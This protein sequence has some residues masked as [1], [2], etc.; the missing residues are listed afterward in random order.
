MQLQC[1]APRTRLSLSLLT[2]ATTGQRVKLVL[3]IDHKLP[4]STTLYIFIVH[5]HVHVHCALQYTYNVQSTVYGWSV[6]FL[7]FRFVELILREGAH[8]DVKNKK[9]NSP[10]WL[11]ANGMYSTSCTVRVY[12]YNDIVH[13]C[14]HV[15]VFYQ[16]HLSLFVALSLSD[17]PSPP[18]SP[19]AGGHLDVVRLLVDH[20]SDLDSQDNRKV[21]CL[22]A[23]F[24]KVNT[25]TSSL[26]HHIVTTSSV[27]HT[28]CF[29]DTGT[30]QGGEVFGG[31]C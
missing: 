9:G 11:A 2:R 23:A 29:C 17:L 13:V 18:L 26:H 1:P 19:C 20:G 6:Q 3:M 15:H 10:L 22:M 25:M 8:V 7:H 16:S 14:V 27:Y 5:V 28:M 31:S 30:F 12:I 21:S 4:T 24:R